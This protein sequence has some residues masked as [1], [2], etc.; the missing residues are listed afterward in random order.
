MWA[1]II[2]NHL[3]G[4][5]TAS[6]VLTKWWNWE[7]TLATRFGGHAQMV[8]EVGGRILATNF[9][10]VRLIY[11]SLIGRAL[12]MTST[13]SVQPYLTGDNALSP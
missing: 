1:T 3:A 10:F 11:L 4:E 2:G 6:P 7:L 13:I 5:P 12:S 9:G 8:T